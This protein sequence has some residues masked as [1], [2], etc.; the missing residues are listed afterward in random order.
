LE[1]NYNP[2]TRPKSS[3]VINCTIKDLQALRLWGDEAFSEMPG[4]RAGSPGIEENASSP[5]PQC[6]GVIWARGLLLLTER[7]RELFFTDME[8]FEP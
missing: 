8:R 3:V 7:D 2:V 1:A 4:G 5:R 6:R